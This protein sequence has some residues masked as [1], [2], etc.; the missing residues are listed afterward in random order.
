[1]PTSERLEFFYQVVSSIILSKQ[2][3][4]T[5]L[6][7]ASVAITT[8]GDYR[9][10]WVR[11][12]VYSIYAVWGLALAYRRIDDDQGRAYQLEH[13]TIKCMR[14]LLYA[15]IRQAHKVELFKNTQSV[16]D[17]LHA[18]YNTA[19]GDTV[20]GDHEW[21][22]LQI[23]ATSI[24]LLSLAQM[25]A[26]GLQII[27]TM[28]EV[29]FVQNLAFYI[30][31]AY[32]TP[33]YGIWERGNKINHGTPELNSSS[34]GMA[35]A[36]LQ[37][38][39]NLN[40]FGSR[41][42]PASVIHSLPDEFT[43]NYT[44]LCSALPRESN[45]K[46]IDAAILSVISFPA[47][48][49][50]DQKLVDHT[51][52][53]IVK[54]LQGRY[55]LKRFLRD[56]HQTVLEDKTRL[57]YDPHELK[58]FENIECEWPL[59]FT[60]LILDAQFRED[61]AAV[62]EYRRLL[63]PLLVDSSTLETFSPGET[64]GSPYQR[65]PRMLLVPEL[66]I[67]PKEAVDAEKNEP[68]SQERVPNEN[69]P[70][71][72]AQSLYILGE[73]I[74]ENLLSPAELDPLGRRFLP[75]RSKNKSDVVV[76]VVLIAETLELQATLSTYGLETQT[77]ESCAPIVISP[78]SA[79]RDAFTALGENSKLQLSGRP[80]RPM[81][82][83]STSK[84]YRCQ[85]RIYAFLPHFMDR[86]EFYLVSD[87][88]YLISV[89][90]QEL[91]F[92]QNNWWGAGRPTMVVM[93]THEMLGNLG[94]TPSEISG[95]RSGAPPGNHGHWRVGGRH[96]KRNL[97]NF[98]MSLRSGSCAGVRTRLGP[99]SE[100]INT[101]R[102]E[103]LDFLK[104]DN[105][106]YDSKWHHILCGKP[107]PQ[108]D[109]R[110]LPLSEQA[111]HQSS[112][113]NWHTK[114][115]GRRSVRRHSGEFHPSSFP[116]KS[117]LTSPFY[118]EEP[119]H[120][121]YDESGAPES[122]KLRDP[123]YNSPTK[124]EMGL[125]C[126]APPASSLVETPSTGDGEPAVANPIAQ[127]D[128]GQA[129]APQD[130]AVD[131]ISSD[132][133][134]LTL[135]DP[136]QFDNSV[137]LLR[138]SANLYDQIDLLHYL[139]SC[140][141]SDHVL[142]DLGTVRSLIEEVYQK[143]MHMKQWSIVRQA[144]GLLN[145]T[146]NSLTVNVADLL[147]RQRPVTVG[148]GPNEHPIANPQS[149]IILSEVIY[150]NCASDVREAPL[151]QEVLTYLGSFIRSQPSLFEGIMRIRVHYVI[152]ALREEISRMKGCDE[153]M[154]VEHLMQLSPFEMK[155]L[156]GQVLSACEQTGSIVREG[157]TSAVSKSIQVQASRVSVPSNLK[158][159]SSGVPLPSL[160][161]ITAESAGF[162]AGHS[163]RIR[164]TLDGQEQSIP[165]LLGRGLN[166][167][168]LDP[169]DGTILETANF[170]T[171]ISPS[172]SD[173]FA[174]MVEFMEPGLIV[175]VLANDDCQGNLT[176]AAIVACEA[177]GATQIRTVSYRDSYCLIGEKG[178][179]R[180]AAVESHQEADNRAVAVLNKVYDLV[181]R[182]KKVMN[183]IGSQNFTTSYLS[184]MMMPSNGKWLRRRK[185]DGALNRVP[186][187]F[188]PKVWG[189]LSKCQGI[190][191][192]KEF[193]PR[194][195]TVS[196]KTPEEF[197][198]GLQVE[199][200]LDHIPDPAERQIAVECVTVIHRIG[201]RNPEIQIKP[202]ALDLMKVVRA[203]IQNY[204]QDWAKKSPNLEA[205]S[206]FTD[207][208]DDIQECNDL[209]CP[210]PSAI[211]QSS[212]AKGNGAPG[213]PPRR[214]SPPLEK[215]KEGAKMQISP[216]LT[217]ERNE[218]LARRL[219]FDLPQDGKDGTMAY[220]AT[221]CVRLLFDVKW[222]SEH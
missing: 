141:G 70:L 191:I 82:S 115:P 163:S 54:K 98:M 35:V 215:M 113:E 62:E 32:R 208:V 139:H 166:V 110:R 38:I 150:K 164:I 154:A 103:S 13:A 93:L 148:F 1:M 80:K 169:L 92:V 200:L 183:S 131:G 36:A 83:L 18:K 147:I 4:A 33:D 3:A 2:N 190:L 63:Q 214:S 43:R 117:P 207:A 205:M 116:T 46:E 27:F 105:S 59:F 99:L 90:E 64:P 26:S 106:T 212:E 126:A 168:V 221:S 16:N 165:G 186:P 52:S 145:K 140:K 7:P 134:T 216:D 85:G 219:F 133:L 198:F 66:Y 22:H 178:P 30:E 155:S 28:D 135:G 181:A 120:M 175:V 182:R 89:F 39:N 91:K 88:N 8:H 29:H 67:V 112:V 144:A 125:A 75:S 171:H 21:G 19:T 197:N 77:V 151:V 79:L 136:S 12:N 41:G 220:L 128:S 108:S 100:M 24:F 14:G 204:W 188:Y 138:N 49:V 109:I 86:E 23:D 156:L 161:T 45:S 199:S 192:G 129:T 118:R 10:A 17:A 72:W 94:P 172:E 87:Y 153:E 101:A 25:T 211:A 174:E 61:Q 167:I 53:E 170:D 146:V 20:V 60:Y 121:L 217:F 142:E 71:V 78:P 132:L 222:S 159:S 160:L 6:I 218:R 34:I 149:P 124:L 81:G 47:F 187:G 157:P 201:D 65:R 193:L 40:L 210:R 196:E 127:T 213:Q 84:L 68:G 189:L 177:L 95:I 58:I 179:E 74:H 55:G 162:S 184:S 206:A 5:G 50:A 69:L 15:M 137:K 56:G 37:A 48:A 114:S 123:V 104:G 76:Q 176:E 102:I 122:F 96:D 9:D 11:D 194:D 97:L 195:P 202:D 152:I 42:G 130:A 209:H 44:T 111:T 107:H 51:R 185:N 173:E 180:G 158:L 57:H 31:R 119:L 143:A 73:L 203:A